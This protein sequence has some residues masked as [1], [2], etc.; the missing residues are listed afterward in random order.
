MQRIYLI[1]PIILILKSLFK[2]L[3]PLLPEKT[4]NN[5]GLNIIS[6]GINQEYSFLSQSTRRAQGENNLFMFGAISGYRK[7]ISVE[8][9]KK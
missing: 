7:T 6:G 4:S 5:A 1:K 8:K 3:S 9:D 2:A